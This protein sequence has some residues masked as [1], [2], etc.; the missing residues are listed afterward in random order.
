[1]IMENIS[2]DAVTLKSGENLADT[3]VSGGSSSGAF[4]RVCSMQFGKVVD[5]D[6]IE[7]VTINGQTIRL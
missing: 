3:S 2:I 1:M 5:I 4:G 6:D 7:S